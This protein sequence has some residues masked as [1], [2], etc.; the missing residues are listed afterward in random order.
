MDYDLT[1]LNSRNF[2]HLVQALGIKAIASGLTPFGD[3]P[4]GGREASYN[5]KMDYP[6]SSDPW[7]GY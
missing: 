1:G 2:E 7:D 5:G 3:G 4:D 6:S